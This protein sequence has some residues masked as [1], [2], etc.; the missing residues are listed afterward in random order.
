MPFVQETTPAASTTEVNSQ[1]NAG[2]KPADTKANEATP[3]VSSDTRVAT[4]AS[5]APE[6]KA[7]NQNAGA[8]ADIKPS[9][10]ITKSETTI[11][12]LEPKAP[13]DAIWLFTWLP[14][15]VMMGL[16]LYLRGRNQAAERARA[17][18]LQAAST[19]KSKKPARSQPTA[20]ADTSG[21]IS[22]TA[23]ERVSKGNSKKN[24]KDKQQQKKKQQSNSGAATSK[25][26]NQSQAVMASTSSSPEVASSPVSSVVNRTEKKPLVERTSSSASVP[27]AT[28]E[29][30]KSAAPAVQPP[31]AIFEPLRKITAVARTEEAE[32]C[33][34]ADAS[35]EQENQSSHRRRPSPPPQVVTTPRKVS[36][37]RFE[38]LNSPAATAGLG[39]STNRWPAEATRPVTAVRAPQAAVP[40][41]N[42]SATVEAAKSTPTP[43]TARGLGAFVKL[44]KPNP[45]ESQATESVE[46]ENESS[47]T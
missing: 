25:A 15:V 10:T 42:P 28:T 19:K 18:A 5:V 35:D 4:D 34:E 29:E 43:I 44:A 1:A 30:L 33:L 6:P 14:L 17:E 22:Q 38:K 36:S 24:K 16:W 41:T 8:K 45:A 39:S 23:G 40:R 32:S 7:E 46:V 21:A 9:V 37:G 31:K 11:T 12:P 20:A 3:S 26:T 47:S 2:A 13:S 27:E